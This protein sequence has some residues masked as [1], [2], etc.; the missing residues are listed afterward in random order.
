MV[1]VCVISPRCKQTWNKTLIDLFLLFFDIM[2]VYFCGRVDCHNHIVLLLSFFFF[3][4]LVCT[5]YSALSPFI[6]GKWLWKKFHYYHSSLLFSKPWPQPRPKDI[7]VL[8]LERLRHGRVHGGGHWREQLS[9]VQVQHPATENRHPALAQV[10][11][12]VC[13]SDFPRFPSICSTL[14][15]LVLSYTGEPVWPSGKALGW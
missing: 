7:R 1:C 2:S 13:C 14:S 8:E 4:L 10:G 9:L 6:F 15:L 12:P 11:L 5:L 3:F